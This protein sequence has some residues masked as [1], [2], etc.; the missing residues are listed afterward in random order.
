VNRSAPPDFSTLQPYVAAWAL[1]TLQER[2]QRR[3]TSTL[4]ELR[5][6]HAAMLPHLEPIIE[7][8][9]QFPLDDIPA[10]HRP[11]AWLALAMC[12]VD[13]PV[14]KWRS[15]TLDEALD[16]RKFSLKRSFYDTDFSNLPGSESP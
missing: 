15:V 1:P 3:L 12:E 4:D 2:R 9:N 16:P 6:F 14:T 10:Q 5:E 7:F 8:L 11:L 13:D